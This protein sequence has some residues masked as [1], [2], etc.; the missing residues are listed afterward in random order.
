VKGYIVLQSLTG[1]VDSGL[2]DILP[3]PLENHGTMFFDFFDVASGEHLF[4]LSKRYRY[5][6]PNRLFHMSRWV[7][8]RYFF[9]PG[10]NDK[11]KFIVC[12]LAPL[13]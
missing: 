2:G 6:P 1:S 11:R 10:P 8:D 7:T 4:T 12:D 9:I 13:E 3:L 5:S